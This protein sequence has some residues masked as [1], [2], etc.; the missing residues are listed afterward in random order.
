MR[1]CQ[2]LPAVLP[3]LL[4]LPLAGRLHL[5]PPPLLHLEQHLLVLGL[6]QALALPLDLLLEQCHLLPKLLS[7]LLLHSEH[8]QG[9]LALQPQVLRGRLAEVLVEDV[10]SDN[11]AE[12]RKD[13]KLLCLP[14]DQTCDD[15]RWPVSG[16]LHSCGQF[17]SNRAALIRAAGRP[18]HG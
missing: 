9:F 5:D 18:A 16:R 1:R 8:K 6:P 3:L 14:Q 2:L 11:L 17:S 4:H 12:A 13:P 7:V 15:A 10:G